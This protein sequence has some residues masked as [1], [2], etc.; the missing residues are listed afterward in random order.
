LLTFRCIENRIPMARCS[1]TGISGFI[2]SCG[3]ATHS[4]ALDQPATAVGRL[5]LDERET[6]YMAHPDVFPIASVFVIAIAIL[7]RAAIAIATKP[8]RLKKA[9]TR[10]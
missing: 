10:S 1:N 6:F 9:A 4:T 2:D 3:R 7:V 8:A 5:A